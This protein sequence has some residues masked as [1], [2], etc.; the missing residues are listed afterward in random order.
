MDLFDTWYDDLTLMFTQGHKVT[1][2]LEVVQ[3]F[4]YKVS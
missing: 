3:S 1:G 4:C 2:K